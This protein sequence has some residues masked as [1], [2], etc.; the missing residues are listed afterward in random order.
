MM[1]HQ[2]TC[3]APCVGRV[4]HE[5]ARHALLRQCGFRGR[6]APF[7]NALRVRRSATEASTLLVLVGDTAISRLQQTLKSKLSRY[8]VH[9]T[10]PD[11]FIALLLGNRA[12]TPFLGR[13]QY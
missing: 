10:S 8:D 9:L 2:S 4:R 3:G 6:A 13:P 1:L 5:L 7:R 11:Y 12:F